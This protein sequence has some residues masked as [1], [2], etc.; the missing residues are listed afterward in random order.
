M[1]VLNS[2]ILP[3]KKLNS[4]QKDTRLSFLAVNDGRIG[5]QAVKERFEGFNRSY[6]TSNSSD[7]NPESK[8]HLTFKGLSLFGNLLKKPRPVLEKKRPI[9]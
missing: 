2:G 5:N 1:K 6:N 7:Q 3:F 9:S 8:K 4:E